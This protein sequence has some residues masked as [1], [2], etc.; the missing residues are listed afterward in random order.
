MNRKPTFN[1]PLLPAAIAARTRQAAGQKATPRPGMATVPQPPQPRPTPV[2]PPVYR[3]QTVPKVLQRKMATTQPAPGA[4]T[5]R[6]PIPPPAYRPQTARVIDRP[7]IANPGPTI[8]Q[9]KT[10]SPRPIA[11]PVYRPERKPKALQPK[12][13]AGAQAI[14]R[15]LAPPIY[16]PAQ[17]VQ[18]KLIGSARQ[19]QLNSAKPA[20]QPV[21]PPIYRPQPTPK[22]LQAKPAGTAMTYLRPAVIQRAEGKGEVKRNDKDIQVKGVQVFV[23]AEESEEEIRQEATQHIDKLKDEFGIS[24][25]DIRSMKAMKTQFY[26]NQKEYGHN[27]KIARSKNMNTIKTTSWLVE[28]LEAFC[29][30]AEIFAP[31]LGERRL[32]S[33]RGTTPQEVTTIGKLTKDPDLGTTIAETFQK[34]KNVAVYDKGLTESGGEPEYSDR[35]DTYIHELTHGLLEHRIYSFVAAVDYWKTAEER[36]N[37]KNAEEPPNTVAEK[38]AYEDMA[39]SMMMFLTE[40]DDLK[41][42]CPQR[43][44]I[45]K[46]IIEDEFKSRAQAQREQAAKLKKVGAM[47]ALKVGGRRVA[48]RRKRRS[49]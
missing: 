12:V 5:A 34:H 33:V 41:T 30:A 32:T 43:Y 48:A 8:A 37:K 2:A 20:H 38:D 15:P 27:T 6:K 17:A 25:S 23:P 9:T 14:K 1:L 44:A 31:I 11:P 36:S 39:E 16:R 10:L 24:V 19:Q 22:V 7:K 29:E 42:D 21:A 46:K 28:E 47:P 45:C 26:E 4:Q 40:D 3:P 13:A 35:F 18:P 49:K